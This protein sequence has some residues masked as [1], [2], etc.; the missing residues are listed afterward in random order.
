MCPKFPSKMEEIQMNYGWSLSTQTPTK[1]LRTDS[2]ITVDASL[3]IIANGLTHPISQ[4]D[5]IWKT[6]CWLLNIDNLTAKDSDFWDDWSQQCV[7]VWTRRIDKITCSFP[8]SEATRPVNTHGSI[9]TNNTISEPLTVQMIITVCV[10]V[11]DHV[12]RVHTDAHVTTNDQEVMQTRVPFS[13]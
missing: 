11:V 1:P 7:C 6:R 5:F 8:L 4:A 13:E 9:I 12:I 3:W 10:C 2:A